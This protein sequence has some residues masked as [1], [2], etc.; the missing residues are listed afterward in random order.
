MKAIIEVD[1][2]DVYRQKR[3]VLQHISFTVAPGEIVAVI[4]PNGC[5]KLSLIHI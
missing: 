2:I 5:G 1:N 4:G 3:H